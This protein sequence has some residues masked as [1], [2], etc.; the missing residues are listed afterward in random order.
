VAEGK[1]DFG[2]REGRLKEDEG[3]MEKHLSVGVM[4]VDE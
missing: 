3:E 1:H 4:P 2:I